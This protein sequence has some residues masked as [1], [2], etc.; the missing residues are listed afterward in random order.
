V[1]ELI[2]IFED[3]GGEFIS[4]V[5]V[6]IEKLQ[7]IK[8]FVFDWD[9]VFNTGQKGEDQYSGF[10]E[11]DAMGLNMLRF[12]YWLINNQQ[13]PLTAIITG[14]DNPSAIRLA[15]RDH[16][17]TVFSGFINKIDAINNLCKTFNLDY[18]NI[19]FFFDDILDL[20]AAK[21][22]GLRFNI[23]RNIPA[24]SSYI[25]KKNLCDYITANLS[26]NYA[27]REVCE[28]LLSLMDCYDQTLDSRI[29]FNPTY[30]TFLAQ[31]N[32]IKTESIN[33]L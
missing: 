29:E 19:A 16:L 5:T 21:V 17:Q 22:C 3:A 2:R 30:T 18:S 23:R 10:T 32:A 31:R 4:P 7:N 14:A 1:N 25:R 15:E 12:G 26:G 27:V 11:P 13:I 6:L 20:S 33:I 9:G 28:L 8:A 24:F